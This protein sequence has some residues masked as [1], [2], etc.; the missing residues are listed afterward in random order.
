MELM[1]HQLDA[2]EQLSSGKILWGGVGSGK[3]AAVL[4]YYMK[5]EKPRDI[6]VITT[7]K[8]R[9]SLDWEGEAAKFGIGTERDATLAGVVVVDSWNNIPKYVD[10]EGAFFIFDE[11]RVVGKGRWVR[12]FIKIAKKNHWVLLTAT[13]GD[14]WM[15]YA[16]VFVANNFYA[17]LSAFK[18]EHVL[19]E[20]FSRYPKIRMYLNVQK[21]E[22]LRNYV[23]VEMPYLQ[24]NK[25]CRNFI[26]VGYDEDL[27]NT[28]YKKRWNPYANKPIKEVSELFRLMRRVVNSDPSRLDMIR[29]FMKFHPKLI[30]F[31]NFNYE[32]ELLRTLK[33][34]I[35][36]AEWNGHFK[37]PIP[38]SDNWIYLV[39]YVAGAEGWNCKET[40]SM[41]L[42]S[43]TYSYKMYE[44]AQGR[45]DRLDTP[46]DTL[47]YYIFVS[48]SKI[49]R[50]IKSALQ[51]KKSF[52]EKNFEENSKTDLDVVEMCQI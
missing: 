30:V 42:Y 20:P 13:P 22:V 16:P 34:D 41:I 24:L 2:I 17:N 26:E 48:N 18:R 15:D 51:S 5:E 38:D 29:Y 7:A 36:V 27:F 47:Y 31:Y 49:D 35:V 4:G 19:Y 28:V 40:D 52:N 46:F 1:E 8:K 45:I 23:L 50:A 37:E 39:Q 14:T 9:D 44:Q 11:Q 12:S 32:L 10:V 3:S 25:R 21:L 6:Y 33:K 43:L